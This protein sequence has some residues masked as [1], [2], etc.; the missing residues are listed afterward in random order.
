MKPY[1]NR[2]LMVYLFFIFRALQYLEDKGYPIVRD[3][4]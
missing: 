4:M 2:K 1:S 3:F